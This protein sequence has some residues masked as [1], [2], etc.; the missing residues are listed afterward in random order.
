MKDRY[1]IDTHKLIYHPARVAAFVDAGDDWLKVKSIYPIYVEISPIGACNHRCTFCALDYVGYKPDTLDADLLAQRLVEMGERGVK[2]VHLAGEGEPLL[3]KRLTDIVVAGADAGIDIGITTNATLIPARFLEEA[4][5]RLQ[6]IKA[7]INAGSAN[8]Y[9]Q[10]HQGKAGDFERAIANLTAMAERKREQN[11]AVTLGAQLVLLPENR[12]EVAELAAICRDRIGLDYLVI[13]P[14]S[15][16][17]FSLTQRY[18]DIDYNAY[19][20]LAASLE[21]LSSDGFQLIYRANAIG[22]YADPN[23]RHYSRCYSTPLFWAYMA[24]NGE[25]YSCSA[26][27]SDKRFSLGNL[28]EQP[29]AEVWEGERRK[30]NFEL[31]RNR[32]DIS[33]CRRNC[34]MDE[35]NR[36]LFDL[37]SGEVPHV[38][39]I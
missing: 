22:K 19:D 30:A 8:T 6:W 29:F 1:R 21:G 5:P 4:L 27:L 2:S 20:D 12:D 25:L 23:A 11:L 33:E 26:Y 36:Y 18:A 10:I 9:Q 15:Q 7:S 14:Y 3:H 28:L 16:H 32:L 31:V 38:N 17:N 13:K 34:R 24:S 39:F 37:A 35:I